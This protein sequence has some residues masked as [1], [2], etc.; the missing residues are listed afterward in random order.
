MEEQYLYLSYSGRECYLRCP[1]RYEFRYIQKIPVQRDPRGSMFGSAIGKV[2]QWFYD[3][4]LWATVDPVLSCLQLVE[5]ALCEV[6]R[7]EGFDPSADPG[8]RSAVRQDMAT[9]V[10]PGVETIR[11]LGLVTAY[12]RAEANLSVLYGSEKHDMTIKLG[13][14]ADFVHSQDRADVCIIDGK[15]SKH[16]EKYVDSGQLIWY[17][18]QHYIKYHV[19]PARIG[20]VFWAFPDDPVKWIAYSSQDMV[21][22]LDQT[23]EVGK[24]IRLKMFD[25]TP[26]GECNRC[27]YK[28][29]C[30]E[31]RKYISSKRKESG[32]GYISDSIFDFETQV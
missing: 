21:Q 23:F 26:S 25:P 8:Y 9:F 15:G 32:G 6:F 14:R 19:A 17:A 27:D 11:K 5:P 3:K 12:S 10:P 18:V 16:R 2:F 28:D 24:K 7:E 20:F 1:R 22:S 4:K 30:E 31:G 29:K 13:G